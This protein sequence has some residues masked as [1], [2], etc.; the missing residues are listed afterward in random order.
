MV[1]FLF[2]ILGRSCEYGAFK[3]GLFTDSVATGFD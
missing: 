1:F 2:I 3:L